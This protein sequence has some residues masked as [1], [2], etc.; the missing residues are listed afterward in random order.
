MWLFYANLSYPNIIIK[1]TP[2]YSLFLLTNL[3]LSS[4]LF[5][6]LKLEP[7]KVFSEFNMDG[8]YLSR[9]GHQ[10]LKSLMSKVCDRRKGRRAK[11]NRTEEVSCV[12]L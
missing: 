11:V 8:V 12:I 2:N 3:S 5:A 9:D 6:E 4:T 7:H 10:T 1:I